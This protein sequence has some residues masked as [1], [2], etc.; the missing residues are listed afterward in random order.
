[1]LTPPGDVEG[2]H[3]AR[4][5]PAT[6]RDATVPGIEAE[7]DLAGES[8]GHDP[9]ELRLLDG[10]TPHDQPGDAG[11][12]IGAGDVERADPPAELTGHPCR[13]HHPGDEVGLHR[14]PRLR[15]VE[16]DDMDP[17]G[18]LI[19]E[20]SHLLD[21]VV[22]KHRLTVVVPLEQTDAASPAEVDRGP[23]I[24]G[25][26]SRGA[27]GNVNGKSVAGRSR[28][29]GGQRTPG[30]DAC[31]SPGSFRDGIAWRTSDRG[32]QRHRTRPRSR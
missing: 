23:Q 27:A 32:R 20:S 26:I 22:R 30:G 25:D 17:P 29:R 14:A 5:D 31:R 11:I 10:D 24:H 21:R 4:V 3:R 18:P 6:D 2:E 13:L 8:L 15:A 1:M 7:N 28:V 9:E 19:D 12:G 16:V